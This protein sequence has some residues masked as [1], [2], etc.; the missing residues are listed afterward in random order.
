ML[1]SKEELRAAHR[2]A[3]LAAVGELFPSSLAIILEIHSFYH[4]ALKGVPLKPA[5]PAKPAAQVPIA[6]HLT[7]S[8]NVQIADLQKQIVELS[9]ALINE[10][11][12]KKEYQNR[13]ESIQEEGRRLF[14]TYVAK[15][16]RLKEVSIEE[17]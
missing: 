12:D 2:E 14:T 7:T 3:A 10:Q 4:T 16:N 11:E 15:A 9:N 1:K 6:S 17:K 13:Y 5:A 8:S